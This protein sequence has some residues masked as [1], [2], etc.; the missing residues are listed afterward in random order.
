VGTRSYLLSRIAL[1]RLTAAVRTILLRDPRQAKGFAL[2]LATM[3][4]DIPST[5]SPKMPKAPVFV[6]FI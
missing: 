6:L 5:S 4:T 1:D 3:H 2:D